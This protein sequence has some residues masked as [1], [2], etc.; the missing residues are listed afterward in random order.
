MLPG[1][2][3]AERQALQAIKCEV[4]GSTDLIKKDGVFVCRYCGMQY[5]LP[6]VQKMLGTVKID[7]SE[8]RNNYFILARRFFAGT[9]YA[10]ALKYYDLALREDPQNWE[11]IY[12]YA[13]TSVATQDCN[14]LYRNLESIINMS[15][16]YLRQIAT[17]TPEENQ[18]VDVNLFIDAHTLFIRKGTELMA[19][20]IRNS[21]A[22]MRKPENYYYAF[23]YSAI[24]VYGTLREL[25]SCFPECIERYEE[26]LLEMITARPEC[27][28]RKARKEILKQL[29]KKIKKR[30]RVKVKS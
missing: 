9:N 10:D 28:E 26:F 14:Y 2:S 17:D 24:D 27:F 11:A 25:F 3:R 18:M 16:V 12:L 22:D 1:G 30:K 7:K 4:C 6:E 19:E 29:S 8:E 5:S 20:Y 15:K 21:G 13:V 23:G